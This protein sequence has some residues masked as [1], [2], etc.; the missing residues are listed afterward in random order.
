[1]QGKLVRRALASKALGLAA[2]VGA[3]SRERHELA[4]YHS[5]W[6]QSFWGGFFSFRRTGEYR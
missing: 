1:M 4:R 3:G 2:A 6:S 5:L